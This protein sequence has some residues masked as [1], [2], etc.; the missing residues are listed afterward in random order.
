MTMRY[1]VLIVGLAGSVGAGILGYVWM[2][3]CEELKVEFGPGVFLR[4][5]PIHEVYYH[6]IAEFDRRA[7]AWPFL[8][9]G[10][11]VGLVGVI[12]AF[13]RRR[14]SGSALLLA[15]AVGVIPFN[16]SQKYVMVF[17]SVLVL[18]G[19]LAMFSGPPPPKPA[20][21]R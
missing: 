16:P 21:A 8:L 1:L 3:E 13:D 18:A 6:R 2:E 14:F 20:F 19:L 9:T 12:L 11:G 5:P 17:G 15:G 4:Q 7:Q 10:A